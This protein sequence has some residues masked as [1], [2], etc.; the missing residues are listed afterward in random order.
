MTSPIPR[1]LALIALA[2]LALAAAAGGQSITLLPS[3]I[4]MQNALGPTILIDVNGTISAG[5]NG[6]AG[7]LK[8]NDAGGTLHAQILGASA[9]LFLGGGDDPGDIILRD[10]DGTTTTISLQGQFG[11]VQLGGPDE[12][13]DLRL[14]DNEPDNEFSINLDG[15]TGN[16]TNQFAGNGL[17][18]AWAR[19][20]ANG[21]VHSC[22][23][24]NQDETVRVAEGIYNVSFSPLGTDVRSRPRLAVLDS[25][26]IGLS[27]GQI[28]LLD[29]FGAESKIRV[30]TENS[31]GDV[32]DRG[33]TLFV[34]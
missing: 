28:S 3:A 33:F 14:W 24:C 1:V 10:N 31:S 34:F 11:F 16:V 18:K 5:A 8:L 15:G 30:I 25:H 21:S 20:N 32:A 29:A 27:T 17:I 22:W 12:D 9:D 26:G 2:V 6:S 19:M 13:G 23:R 4:L 7:S